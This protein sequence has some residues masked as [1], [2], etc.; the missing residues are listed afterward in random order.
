MLSGV[1]GPN[2]TGKGFAIV[3]V[4]EHAVLLVWLVGNS[5][6]SS[7][8]ELT[9]TTAGTSPVVRI[10]QLLKLY[11]STILLKVQYSS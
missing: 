3:H 8:R 9:V 5:V 11:H 4:V 2:S 1:I 10:L 7:R 6:K